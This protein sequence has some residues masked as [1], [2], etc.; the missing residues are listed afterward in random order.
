MTYTGEG[1]NT[2]TNY[3]MENSA[4]T[5]VTPTV[6]VTQGKGYYYENAYSSANGTTVYLTAENNNFNGS[7]YNVSGYWDEETW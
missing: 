6:S 7:A 2:I 1:S 5:N 4:T 3:W